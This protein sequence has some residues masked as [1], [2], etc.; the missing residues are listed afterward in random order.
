[1][2]VGY[3]SNYKDNKEKDSNDVRNVVESAKYFLLVSTDSVGGVWI[4]NSS[5]LPHVCESTFFI[6]YWSID[7]GAILMRNNM[8]YKAIGIGIVKIKM[9]NRV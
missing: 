3:K 2:D 6:S 4:L 9:H 7:G 5:T 1:M 8:S